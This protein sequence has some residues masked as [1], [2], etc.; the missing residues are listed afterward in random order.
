MKPRKF[1]YNESSYFGHAYQIKWQNDRLELRQDVCY[2][3]EPNSSDFIV[4]EP[5]PLGAIVKPSTEDWSSFERNVRDL[6]L[7]PVDPKDLICDGTQVE[8]WITFR[9]RLIKFSMTNPEFRGFSQFRKL[10]NELTVCS[11]CPQGIFESE[12]DFLSGPVTHV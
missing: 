6:D 10:V 9:Y 4:S 11:K 3:K 12:W 7:D 2:I 5:T 8:I 1:Y